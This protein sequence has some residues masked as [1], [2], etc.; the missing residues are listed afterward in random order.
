LPSIDSVLDKVGLA[1]RPGNATLTV[2]RV[3]HIQQPATN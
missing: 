3:E 1:L 2:Y